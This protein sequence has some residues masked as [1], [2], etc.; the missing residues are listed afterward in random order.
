MSAIFRTI[1]C[2]SIACSTVG[3][4]SLMTDNNTPVKVETVAADGTDVKEASC[5]IVSGVTRTEFKTPAVVPIRKASS[6]VYLECKKE[7]LPDGRATL[8]ARAG[9]ATF[10]N[11]IAG[12]IIGAVVDQSTGKAYNYPEWVRVVMGKYLKFDRSDHKD[13]VQTPGKDAVDSEKKP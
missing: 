13:G 5:A 11:I 7:G 3:C 4:A 1:L 6:D 9:A 8:V 10:G 12:G 2:L